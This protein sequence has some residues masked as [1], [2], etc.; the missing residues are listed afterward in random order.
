MGAL[1]SSRLEISQNLAKYEGIRAPLCSLCP[2]SSHKKFKRRN[3]YTFSSKLGGLKSETTSSRLP[4]FGPLR[5]QNLTFRFSSRKFY[6]IGFIHRSPP[7]S[8]DF[9]LVIYWMV[10]FFTLIQYSCH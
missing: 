3:I 10:H 7:I 8:K 5:D 2:S 1:V 6:I 9:Q 4:Q